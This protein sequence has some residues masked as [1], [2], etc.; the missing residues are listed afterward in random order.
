MFSP[1]AIHYTSNISIEEENQ[2]FFRSVVNFPDNY[3]TESFTLFVLCFLHVLFIIQA[4]LV[5]KKKIKSFFD[6]W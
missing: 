5:L 3:I 4:T 1:R 6:P 2:V